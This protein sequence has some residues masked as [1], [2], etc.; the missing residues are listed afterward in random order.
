MTIQPDLF[1]E[2]A[3][4]EGVDLEYKSAKGGLPGSLWETYSAF[5]NTQG[6]TIYLGVAE[7]NGKLT[8]QG[9]DN[10]EALL[11][12]LWDT[13]NNR[14]KV[15][16]NLLKDAN[17]QIIPGPK[18]DIRLIRI[19]VPRASRWERPIY[20]DN[21]P[22]KGTFRRNN[23]GD[24]RCND[25]EVRRMFAD[26]SEESVDQRILEHFSL[27][28]LHSESIQQFR[29]HFKS[30]APEHPWHGESDLGLLKKLGGWRKDRATGLEGLTLAGLLMF[31]KTDTILECVPDFHVDYRERLSNDPGVRWSDRLTYDGRW[32]ANLFQ[33]Y[34]RAMLKIATL[35]G[36]KT[37]F[38]VDEQGYRKS[39]SPVHEALQEALVNAL[40]HCD[41]SGQG[42]IVID[43]F[44]DH[45]EFSNPGTLLVSREQLQQGGISQCRNTN[46]QKM[47]Q[48]LGIGDKAGSG[49][50]KIRR[51]WN[52]KHWQAPSIEETSRPDRVRLVL[53]MASMLPENVLADLRDFFGDSFEQLDKDSVY[54]L[55][56]TAM[57]GE[58]SNQYLQGFL[59][60][61]R[62]DITKLLQ[63]L[64]HDGFLEADGAARGRTYRLPDHYYG[65]DNSPHGGKKSPHS[66]ENSP[67]LHQLASLR[68]QVALASL[69]EIAAPARNNKSLAR[70]EMTALILRLCQNEFLTL[71][72]LAGLLQRDSNKLRDRHISP[73]IEAGQLLLK[74]PH[75]PKHRQQAYKAVSTTDKDNT[76]NP[77]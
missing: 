33:F 73:M 46:L 5:A 3:F 35:P 34:Q 68:R 27:D 10:P 17:V 45:F 54:V 26:Q 40:V 4:Y 43:C 21:D 71:K 41:Y 9:V 75:S 6:G 56:K 28:D 70:P 29:Q 24:Y 64:V 63:Q 57:E 58:I 20:I 60:L 30:R 74:H 18:G 66:L 14:N 51:S 67:H 23:E 12:H 22:F 77:A 48:M 49:L 42:G 38:Q 32:E 39:T 31:G 25:R 59:T 52:E 76:E 72:E 15:N 65:G 37:P 44:P 1:D 2:L 8:F 61:H 53:S 69:E 19:D 11:K 55:A 16:L 36:L 7:K 13:V 50:D 62:T 47:F